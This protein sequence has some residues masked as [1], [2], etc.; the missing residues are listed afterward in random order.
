MTLVKK[1][2]IKSVDKLLVDAEGAEYKVLSCIDYN[3][4]LIKEIIFEKKHFDGTFKQGENF[5]KLKLL[6][7][8]NKY[9]VKDLDKENCKATKQL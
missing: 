2:S 8:S 6:L 7:A 3:K 5:E 9:D 1:Y 4:I